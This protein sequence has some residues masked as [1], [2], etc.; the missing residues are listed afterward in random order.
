[1]HRMYLRWNHATVAGTGS[2][3]EIK[4]Q[5]DAMVM[6]TPVFSVARQ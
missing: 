5:G 2:M 4:D 1:M 3:W 6:D